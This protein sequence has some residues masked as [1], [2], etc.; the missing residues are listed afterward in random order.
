M[1]PV[2]PRQVPRPRGVISH[3]WTG[4]C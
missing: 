1:L 3:P 2:F 4:K